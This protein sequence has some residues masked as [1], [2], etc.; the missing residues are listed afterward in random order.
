M[1]KPMLVTVPFVL[2]LFDVW[3]L[4]RISMGPTI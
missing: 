4:K 2:L 1:A 3:P